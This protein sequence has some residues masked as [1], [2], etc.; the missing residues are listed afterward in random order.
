MTEQPS[1]APPRDS[2][3]RAVFI[4]IGVAFLASLATLIFALTASHGARQRDAAAIS[5]D[6]SDL[7]AVV[8]EWRAQIATAEQTPA[9]QRE[10]LIATLRKRADALSDWKPRTPCGQTAQERLRAA[11]D[12]RLVSLSRQTPGTV[13]DEQAIVDDALRECAAQAGRDVQG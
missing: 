4:V 6:S 10:D 11:M 9:D 3:R 8:S 13:Q 1:N 7:H 5:A 2:G 12:T